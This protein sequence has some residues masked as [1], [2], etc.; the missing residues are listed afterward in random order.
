MK[1][2]T[3]NNYPKLSI[4]IPNYN[5]GIY[6]EETICSIINQNYDNIEIIII[7][8]GSTDNSLDIVKK[9]QNKINYWIS[10][11]DAGQADAINRGLQ[12]ATGDYVAYINSDDVYLPNAFHEIFDNKKSLKSDF[13][14]GDVMIGKDINNCKPNRTNKNEMNI[15]S[16]IQFYY[17]AAYII[18]S[19]S[20][21]IKREFLLKNNLN[22]LNINL[23]YCMDLD[24]YCRISRC[25]PKVYKYKKIHSF[26]RINENTKT[27]KHSFKMKQEAL[28]VAYFYLDNLSIHEKKYFFHIRLL[29]FILFKTYHFQLKPNLCFLIKI[30]YKTNFFAIQ[31]RRFLGLLKNQLLFK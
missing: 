4:I 16:L 8:G 25:K 9:Y 29:E 10:E 18:P 5:Y 23:H 19:Q 11:S 20:V 17:S 31:D 14:Y 6:I 12:V 30:I 26:F 27:V 15:I 7:D 21:F 1:S 22:L 2:E 28:K 24:W 3:Q 13:I